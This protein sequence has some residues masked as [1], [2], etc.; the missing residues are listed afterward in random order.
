[1]FKK[2]NW[3]EQPLKH[4][5]FCASKAR[6]T[7]GC[8]GGIAVR[9]CRCS[10]DDCIASRCSVD[11]DVWNNRPSAREANKM[12]KGVFDWGKVVG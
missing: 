6:R 12:S 3:I 1:M 11:Y 8:V 10:N 4:C 2:Y 9:L 7:G 5:P